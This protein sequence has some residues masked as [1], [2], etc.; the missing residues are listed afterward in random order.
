MNLVR[1]GLVAEVDEDGGGGQLADAVLLAGVGDR[2]Q[3]L[4]GIGVQGQKSGGEKIT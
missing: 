2:D 3:A 1:L 4:V